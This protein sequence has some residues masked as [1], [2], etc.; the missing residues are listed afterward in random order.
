MKCKYPD[1]KKKIDLVLQATNKCKCDLI[2]CDLHKNSE[3][4]NCTFDYK[5]EQYDKLKQELI[6]VV[7]D[8]IKNKI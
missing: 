7:A 8:K 6:K 4:H 1:C 5:K 2:F 3:I